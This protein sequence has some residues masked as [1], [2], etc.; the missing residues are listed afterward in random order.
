[1]TEPAADP[2]SPAFTVLLVDDEPAWLRA[3][4]RS[5]ERAAGI[6][7]VI[8]CE[9]ARRVEALL[10]QH[11]VG[12][13]LLDLTMPHRS[14][15][16]VLKAVAEQH[17]GTSVIVVSGLN[18][19]ETAVRCM[20]AGAFDYF[21]KT[22]EEDR[23]VEG[24]RRAVRM[25]E[26]QRENREMRRRVLEDRLEHPEAF[27][28][29]VTA[30]R[31]MRGIFHYVEAVARGSQP[32][33]VTGESGTGKELVARA[34]HA[35]SG[36]Q[37]E[38]VA[39]NVAGLDDAVFADTLFGHARGAFTGAAEARA[40]MI[41]RAAGGTLFFDEIGDLSAASQVKLL[42]LLQE[43]EYYPLGSDRPQHTDARVVC[44]THQD[45]AARQAAGTFRKDLF[46]RLRAHHVHLPPLR[47]RP[48]D[49]PLLLEHFLG[50]AARE[51]GAPCPAA[52][53]ALAALLAGHD[54]PGNVRELRSMVFDAVGQAAGGALS[55]DA[56]RRGLSAGAARLAAAA[57]SDENP[58]R[59]AR[60]LPA[61]DMALDL[62]V[63][64]ALRRAG[65]NQ[66]QAARLLGVSQSALSKRLKAARERGA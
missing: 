45:L 31:A 36:R 50:E 18:Q 9:D 2:L 32:V 3:M 44:A 22:S 10:D 51:F 29:I 23:I 57:D 28:A 1:M 54:F 53:P 58:F 46:Y 35:L 64:E 37:G 43:G 63:A 27:A 4:A 20:Q 24:V 56:F 42:R 59:T 33:L 12:L 62:L 21:V 55:L 14:G 25:Q 5:L 65:G 47:D 39:V 17:P 60:R 40:G 38:L 7:N 15:E 26:L 41:Q 66:T 52:P 6:T 61:F 16:E 19:L 30:D 34:L 49:V 11:D 8:C 13:V 48:D